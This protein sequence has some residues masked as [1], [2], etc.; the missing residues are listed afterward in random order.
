MLNLSIK[1]QRSLRR[2]FA[3]FSIF[4]LLLQTLNGIFL[5]QPVYS[6]EEPTPTPTPTVVEE[7]TPTPEPTA[8][9][10]LTPTPEPTITVDPS[11]TP[12][13]VEEI[14]PTPEVSPTP[15]EEILPTVT[16]TDTPT[17]TETTQLESQP[18][19]PP[20]G[21]STPS[22]S[23]SSPSSP[24]PSNPPE[25]PSLPSGHL[26]AL[27]ISNTAA[28][29]IDNLD[30]EVTAEGSA[31][32]TTDKLDYAP[33]DTVLITGSGFI[34]NQDYTLLITGTD[35]FSFSDKV[36]ADS[37]GNLVYSYQLDGTYRPNYQA[38]AKDSSGAVIA[39][40]S[41]TDHDH[42]YVKINNDA[43]ETNTLNVTLNLSWSGG[44]S[45]PTQAKFANDTSTGNDC[46]NLG[47]GF[48]SNWESISD[49]G[50]NNST[51]KS[52]TLASG[53]EGTRKVCVQS[54]HGSDTKSDDDSINYVLPKPDLTV[55]KSNNL[56][57]QNALINQIFVWKIKVANT[58][59]GTASFTNNQEIF[60]DEM[61]SS[62]VSYA[63]PTVSISGTTG[64]INCYKS[65]NDIVCKA[66]GNV[67][68]PSGSYFDVSINVTPTQVGTLI[69]PRSGHECKVDADGL[70][71]ESNE[72]NNNCQ[73]NSVKVDNVAP[74]ANP[75][76]SRSCGVDI[77]LVIDNSASISTFQL[78]QMKSAFT[79]FV[80]TFLPSTSTQFSL[81]K[82][83]STGAIAQTFTGNAAEIKNAINNV[84]TSS[85]Y[86]N[87]EDA[88]I[89][90]ESTFDPRP[91]VPNLIVLASD[92]DPTAS[93][94][95]PNDL[96]QPNAHLA[97]AIIQANL[98]KTGGTRIIT[99]GI[100][101]PSQSNLEAISSHDAYYGAAN[102]NDLTNT[103]HQLATDL[104][105]GT[106][107]VTK[108]MDEDGDL[109]TTNDQTPT[110][111]W[112][113]NIG[114]IEKTTGEN[115]LTDPVTL[116][117]D[118]YSVGENGQE[119]YR[120]LDASCTGAIE[121]GSL[122]GETIYGI[123]ID[124]TSIVSCTFINTPFQPV[125]GDPQ[126]TKSND[127]PNASAGDTITYTLTLTNVQTAASQMTIIDVLPGGFNYIAGSGKVD[128][129]SVDPIVED[130][131]LK[132]ELGALT[133]GQVVTIT[134][135]ALTETWL[136]GLSY[137]NLT[138]CLGLTRFEEPLHC[139][140][141]G[142]KVTI[143]RSFSYSNTIEE[144]TQEVLGTSTTDVLGAATGS[145]TGWSVLAF[146]MI[147][148]GLSIRKYSYKKEIK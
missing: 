78:N 23:N 99:L 11:P 122:D 117:E 12:T 69:N 101:S 8:A 119:G 94:A 5:Y 33:T 126:L 26:S 79:N 104:C 25:V 4:S 90:A 106:I 66:N 115:G 96:N 88:L 81:T 87:W 137:Y 118:S 72:T 95:G 132:W 7:I 134:Y 59:T 18:N 2:Y 38:V 89:K 130:S 39:S 100:G 140:P 76:L 27:V 144:S 98:I 56:D 6:Q 92:G 44:T 86:T 60:V 45:D 93:S 84:H 109:Q 9:V 42:F 91:S 36:T 148:G 107:T 37:I 70:I 75:A 71:G 123:Q 110:A 146:L 80:D 57:G 63:N 121:N 68:M 65:S 145:E 108:I 141:A 82:F 83:N 1:K 67:S 3:L 35:N 32:L 125:V 105:G 131:T 22:D 40:V 58:G 128:G 48:W 85:G 120:F 113:F 47:S 111:D 19:A 142:S 51:T 116:A 41:F 13:V 49:T 50:G 21:E 102:F 97:P 147:L 54:K 73:S 10:E 112:T 31:V 29:S 129:V 34:A 77:A 43:A 46:G 124:N 143:G 55:T 62:N 127:K 135:Q 17:P 61:P 64:T 24:N 30:L 52:W 139:S 28:V 20:S 53:T 136:P 74:I 133:A 114:G 138:T 16:P 14:T 103:L 15:T